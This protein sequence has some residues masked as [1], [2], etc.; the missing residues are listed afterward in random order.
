MQ[1][2]F[3]S[4][5]RS[6]RYSL[7][8]LPLNQQ[9]SFGNQ[10]SQC[11]SVFAA[12]VAFVGSATRHALTWWNGH[13]QSEGFWENDGRCTTSPRV[14]QWARQAWREKDHLLWRWFCSSKRSSK[15]RSI[16]G[17]RRLHD[18][19]GGNSVRD[20]QHGRQ[21]KAGSR[22]HSRSHSP[23]LENII[24]AGTCVDRLCGEVFC[25]VTSSAAGNS[26]SHCPVYSYIRPFTLR[27]QTFNLSS[28][29]PT[30]SPGFTLTVMR[31]WTAPWKRWGHTQN[32]VLV[33]SNIVV[34]RE[35]GDSAWTTYSSLAPVNNVF[36][37]LNFV[38]NLSQQ[39]AALIHVG[40]KN[41][42]KE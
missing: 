37:I 25:S 23:P 42:C 11:R 38:E 36:L 8:K 3:T 39:L 12:S 27:W 34:I 1:R 16:I 21:L 35:T 22:L 19:L 29:P 24:W 10:A 9:S 41:C 40:S 4:P 6:T 13:F 5:T 18:G 14:S 26:S 31:H 7:K 2:G 17:G 32:V 15:Q 28:C 33:K 20:N 30:K